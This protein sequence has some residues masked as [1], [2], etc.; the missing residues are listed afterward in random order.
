MFLRESSV[1]NLIGPLDV[2][3]QVIFPVHG[4]CSFRVSIYITNERECL[5]QQKRK[6]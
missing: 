2:F 1:D 6:N 4:S 5:V 3:D